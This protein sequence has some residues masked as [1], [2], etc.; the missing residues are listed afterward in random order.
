M[1]VHYRLTPEGSRFTVQAFAGGLLSFLGHSPTFAIRDFRGAVWSDTGLIDDARLE[2]VVRTDSLKV[3]GDLA[4]RDREEIERR[5][6]EEVLETDRFPEVMYQG[7]EVSASRMAAGRYRLRIGGQVSLRSVTNFLQVEA[8]L[9]I[10]PDDIRLAGEF[11]LRP[12]DYGVK[13]VTAFGG[14]IQLKDHLRFAFDLL[15]HKEGP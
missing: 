4:P 13:P 11:A 6:R 15:G 12:S 5:L 7:T 14:A 10:F 8:G 2:V 1:S 9:T 3:I